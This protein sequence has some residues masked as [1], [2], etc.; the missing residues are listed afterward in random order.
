MNNQR[1]QHLLDLYLSRKLSA[2]EEQ[3]LFQLIDKSVYDEEIREYLSGKWNELNTSASLSN[4][5][6][7]RILNSILSQHEKKPTPIHSS[8]FILRRLAVAAAVVT[9]LFLSVF[10]IGRKT[11]SSDSALNNKKPVVTQDKDVPPGHNGAILKLA[12][13][14][15]LVLDSMQDG[16]I[17]ANGNT[18]ALKQ[19]GQ[20][21]YADGENK[22][23]GE[24]N[25]VETP[26][27]RQFQLT[28]EDGTKVWLNASSSI[29]FPV[30]FDGPQRSVEITGEVYFEVAKNKQKPFIVKTGNMSVEVLGTQ[31]NVNAYNDETTMKTTLVEG[32]VKIIKDKSSGLLK[33][34][35][36]AQVSGNGNLQIHSNINIEETLSWKN[37]RMI[38]NDA[39]IEAIMR[40]VSKWYD[41]DVV[42]AG[43]VPDRMFTADI[44]RNTNLSELL[45]VLELSNV[46]FKIDGRKLVVMP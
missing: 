43:E 16:V 46:H 36:Q 40:Q 29:R 20:L 21:N 12:D 14:S 19:A 27:G 35:Q 38:F 39:G 37:G 9:L 24:L 5:K 17:A 1:L 42:Y 11:D 31:F 41:V 4:E 22:R 28:L 45:K 7:D 10:Y 23:T 32:S 44:S 26:R 8:S 3:E 33:P 25:T 30:V 6:S 34:G 13:G 15:A 2:G 18:L